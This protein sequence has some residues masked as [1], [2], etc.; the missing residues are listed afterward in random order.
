MLAVAGAAT[1]ELSR[2]HLGAIS[3]ASAAALLY[4]V[5][6]G[7]IIA[8]T[9]YGW[10]LNNVGTQL[11]STY[12]YVNPGVAVILGWAFIGEHIGGK[13]IS[14]GL[15]I[16]A[17]VG[18]LFF[19]QERHGHGADPGVAPA[20]HPRPGRADRVCPFR[21]AARRAPPDPRVDRRYP[22][23]VTVFNLRNARL[24]TGEQLRESVE[25]Q[26]EPLVLGGQEYVPEPD[27]TPAELT[28]TKATT[29]TVFELSFRVTLHG[30]C[31][32]CLADATLE[33]PINAPRVPGDESRR[34]RR[35]GVA[36]RRGRQPRPLRLGPG[37]D[38]RSRCRTRSSAAPTAPASARSAA[39][40]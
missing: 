38:S 11:L 1:G 26:L 30:P 16:L 6:F 19:A 3:P 37:R 10:L 29:G 8:F 22:R 35:A 9:A 13:E 2:V 15:V 34:R 14:A 31:F 40:T 27:P 18:M 39:W 28:I 24:R 7:S 36:V 32:R 33:Q 4:L 20:L 5:V 25:V 23:R 12:A 17:S 21:A